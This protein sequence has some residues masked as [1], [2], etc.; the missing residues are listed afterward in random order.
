MMRSKRT[1]ME[2]VEVKTRQVMCKILLY[3]L[4]WRLDYLITNTVK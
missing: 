1:D 2:E 3:Y 4:D